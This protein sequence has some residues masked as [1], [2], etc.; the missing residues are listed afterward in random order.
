[1]KVLGPVQLGAVVGMARQTTPKLSLQSAAVSW[2][3][4][5]QSVSAVIYADKTFIGHFR[6]CNCAFS[7]F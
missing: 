2:C 1:L 5:Y 3:R 7:G 4:F 6:V